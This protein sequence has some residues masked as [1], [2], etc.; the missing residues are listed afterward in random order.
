M[1]H[2]TASA[3]VCSL[4]FD[5]WP[6]QMGV[7]STKTSA[8]RIFSRSDGDGV[9]RAAPG[10]VAAPGE[11][12]AGLGASRM[13]KDAASASGFRVDW[14]SGADCPHQVV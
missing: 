2:L 8:A 7:D 1:T 11:F 13:C 10:K 6:T 4:R 12:S 14:A 3:L 9:E 5:G